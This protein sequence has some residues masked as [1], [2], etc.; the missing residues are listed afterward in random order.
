[1]AGPMFIVDFEPHYGEMVDVS[2]LLRRMVCRNPSKFT[3]HGTGTYVIGRGD[4]AVVDPGPRDEQHVEALLRALNG[5]AFATSSSPTHG[6]HSPA[7][8]ALSDATGAP[9]LGFGPH[10]DTALGEGEDHDDD[11]DDEGERD[12]ET[13]ETQEPQIEDDPEFQRKHAPDID[14]DPETALAHGDIV[15]GPGY[16]VEALHTPGHISNHLC[17]ALHEEHAVLSGDHVMGWSTTIIPPPDGDVGAYLDSLRVLLDRPQDRRLYPTH[18][19]PVEEHHEFV[20]ALLD[21]RLAREAGILAQLATGPKSLATSSTCSTPMSE[22][23]HKPAARSVL[24][25]SASSTTRTSSRWR[26]KVPRPCRR[27]RSGFAADEPR[28][29]R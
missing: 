10:P 7:A 16:T 28:R 1:M 25:H 18:G 4:V 17:F 29:Q 24:S 19:A 20:A 14:F 22:G 12:G 11:T 5:G 3:F 6:D 15:N 8:A 2:P 21:H 26:S 13:D 27:R 9:V 23:L